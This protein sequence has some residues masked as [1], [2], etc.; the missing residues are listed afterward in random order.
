M[1]F[2]N[3]DPGH[4]VTWTSNSSGTSRSAWSAVADIASVGE[5][6]DPPTFLYVPETTH[7]TATIWTENYPW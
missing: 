3:T 6:V 2:K 5:V 7:E 4:G 1:A